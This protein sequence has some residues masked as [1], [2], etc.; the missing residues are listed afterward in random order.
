MNK[1]HALKPIKHASTGITWPSYTGAAHL[2]GTTPDGRCTV[3][4]DA[5]LGAPV[6]QNGSDLLADAMRVMQFNDLTF[7]VPGG[8]VD[9]I[10]FALNG[11]T[12]G[13]GG[14]DHMG[15]DYVS[16]AQIEVCASFGNSAR[17]TALFEAELSECSMSS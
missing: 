10:I 9:V 15:C 5:S 17:V 6:L 11:A 14:A 4:V 1:S 2:I 3:Y 13:T 7:G 12:D 16:G 8:H